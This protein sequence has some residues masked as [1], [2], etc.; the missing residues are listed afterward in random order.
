VEKPSGRA[1]RAG[2]REATRASPRSQSQRA[3]TPIMSPWAERGDDPRSR[4]GLPRKYRCSRRS[5]PP[6]FAL[7][8]LARLT[9][10]VRW[11]ASDFEER[12]WGETE[13]GVEKERFDAPVTLCPMRICLPGA[14]RFHLQARMPGVWGDD[15]LHLPRSNRQPVAPRA[16]DVRPRSHSHRFGVASSCA[17]AWRPCSGGRSRSQCVYSGCWPFRPTPG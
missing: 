7:G 9:R 8:R 12:V 14:G 3:I 16:N 13:P 15:E 17:I 4:R 11:V 6:S 2:P 5:P 10:G 1:P